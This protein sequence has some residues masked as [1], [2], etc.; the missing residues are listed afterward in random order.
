MHANRLRRYFQQPTQTTPTQPGVS[1]PSGFAPL[2]NSLGQGGDIQEQLYRQ[3]YEQARQQVRA[4]LLDLL[5][6]RARLLGRDGDI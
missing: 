5:R 3:A 1:V 4:K 6:S 2:P